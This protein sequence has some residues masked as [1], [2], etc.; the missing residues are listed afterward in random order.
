MYSFY[1]GWNISISR[2]NCYGSGQV[3]KKHFYVTRF[4]AILPFLML[5]FVIGMMAVII[6]LQ[7]AI[8]ITALC[9]FYGVTFFNLFAETC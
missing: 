1:R 3:Q 4:K 9:F 6:P 2:L 8:G 5:G 7:D